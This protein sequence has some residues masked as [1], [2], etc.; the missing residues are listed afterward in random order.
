MHNSPLVKEETNK[1]NKKQIANSDNTQLKCINE[2]Q[3]S[4]ADAIS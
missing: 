1:L 4:F 2:A 3:R